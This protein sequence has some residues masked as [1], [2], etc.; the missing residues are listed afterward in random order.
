VS[1]RRALAVAVV[2]LGVLLLPETALAQPSPPLTAT[3]FFD[4]PPA[5]LTFDETTPIKIKLVLKNA[6]GAPIITTDGFSATDFWRLIYFVLDGVGII[7][8][9]AAAT[10]HHDA[11]YGTCHYRNSVLVPAI[12][13]VPVEVLAADF[14]LLFTFDDARAHFDLTR[15]G[16]Y[17]V[18]AKIS[19]YA[20]AAGAIISDCNIEFSGKSLLSISSDA[21][22]AGR[23]QFDIVSN[24]LE[25]FVQPSDTTPPTTTAAP[26]PA[27]NASGWNNQD[28]TLALAATDNPG[29]SGVK[30]IV[31]TLFGAQ[32]GTQTISG[33][34]GSVGI[35]AEGTT[36][37]FFNAEDNAGNKEPIKSQTVRLDKTSPV[38]TPPASIS[39]AATEA[40]GARGSAS[41]V[42]AT[43]LAGGTATDNLDPSPVRLAPQVSGA[44]VG[45]TTLFPLGTTTVVAF[46]FQDV[47][48]N[49][50]SANS[51]V[52]VVSGRPT[53]S[54]S[55]V[56]R[57]AVNPAINFFDLRFT[58]TGTGA[59]RNVVLTQFS[60]KTLAGTGNV[61]YEPTRSPALPITLG[62]LPV[63]VSRTIRVFLVVPVPV[64]RFS[65]TENGQLQDPIGTTSPF[66]TSQIVAR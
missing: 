46:R 19:F 38:V 62:D 43:F 1:R 53:I 27:A 8:N 44:N 11:V 3:L 24:S 10:S 61:S 36:T 65:I 52:T 31:V 23:Q 37:V 58:N 20:Y 56:G 42:L 22:T 55:V 33:A 35:T 16:R 25:F 5:N 26:S 40:A 30:D 51:S 60:F 34:G 14:G 47:A 6:S 12:Q 28:V 39:V 9:P 41:P 2:V 50:G 66:S 18:T 49:L 13:V 64:T 4:N 54:G 57:G 15:A 63:G 59:A 45:N 21:G 48:G 17:T 32:A 7:T 29:G